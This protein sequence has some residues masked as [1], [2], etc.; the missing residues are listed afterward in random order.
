MG[1]GGQRG[2]LHVSRRTSGL[3]NLL[4]SLIN[5]LLGNTGGLVPTQIT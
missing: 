2:I 1:G 4:L 5:I 3:I